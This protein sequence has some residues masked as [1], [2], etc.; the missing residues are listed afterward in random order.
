MQPP[1]APVSTVASRSLLRERAA[2]KEAESLL[3]QKSRELYDINQNLRQL[4][5][6]IEE[7]EARYRSLV[8]LIPDA[9]WIHTGGKI[10]FLN[11]AAQRLFGAASAGSLLGTDADARVPAEF[12]AQLAEGTY[13]DISLAQQQPRSALQLLRLDG[14]LVDVEYFGCRLWFNNADS[15]M[16]V[17][18][19]VT[20]RRQQEKA[21][22]HQATHDQ[23]TGLPN[24]ALFL[25]RL[26][27]AIRRAERRKERLAVVFLDLDKFKQVNDTLGH[28]VGDELL[29][30]VASTLRHSVRDF[31]TVAR[32][33][34]DEFVLLLDSPLG[35][36]TPGMIAERI[37][38]HL[39]R[40]V[41]LAGQEHVITGSMGLSL[42]PNDG[43]Q[44]ENLL[45]QADIAM[46]RAK[47]AGRNGFQFFT[48]EMQQ[49]L[50]ARVTLEQ[51]LMRALQ[52]DEFV[53]HYQPQ[54][55]LAS[56]KVIGL[57]AL[58]RWQSPELGLVPPMQFIPVAEESN[59]ITAIG[60]WVLDKACATLRA[61]LDAGVPVVPVAV[62]VAA[63][64]FAHQNMETMLREVLARYSLE[65]G[66]IEFELT[67]SLS[68]VDPEASIAL[69][70][71]LKA[72]GIT[73]SIDDFGTGYSNLSY[74][75]RFPV[76]KLK[77]DQ[78]FTRGMASDPEDRS[79]VTA[80]IR[81]AH[82]LGLRAIAEGVETE[83]QMQL[84]ARHGCDE[85]QGY[86]FSRPL[87]E[88]GI[89]AML[90]SGAMLEVPLT[91]Q[92]KPE[93][94]RTV[95]LVDH[96]PRTQAHF[97]R[98]LDSTPYE[99]LS[100]LKME[101]AYEVLASRE[102]G[103]VLSGRGPEGRSGVDFFERIKRLYPAA[104]RVLLTREAEGGDSAAGLADAINLGAVYK[105]IA[106]PDDD[107]HVLETLASAFEQY[108]RQAGAAS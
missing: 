30:V 86:Y 24:R 10:V 12:H 6:H 90:R 47:Q 72:I 25:D 58:L 52:R 21:I 22:E 74:L 60:G 106:A 23:L 98:L 104:V 28:A 105:F 99:L 49:R 26:A 5:S 97:R 8:E 94:R 2:R 11:P 87:A 103:V 29:R 61:W 77:I 48:Q 13:N 31:D 102:V 18:H 34:G 65:P 88:P 62:N 55:D 79:I 17:A 53:L 50:D 71:R 32:L 63:S 70:H 56:G 46:Y 82:S 67:E 66:L 95:L 73:M 75:K 45:R 40:P 89:V 42:Y 27:H 68:M 4:N 38:E 81:L 41:L 16:S 100:A 20:E 14:A 101:D 35:E 84:L 91:G 107:A 7:S 108:E 92:R 83:G 9:I 37:G 33:G 57:E 78:S 15:V 93:L 76:D 59:L 1:D 96:E 51:G 54:V 43:D 44:A 36:T 19:D 39:A 80:V 85:I 69:M 3:E 64:Q